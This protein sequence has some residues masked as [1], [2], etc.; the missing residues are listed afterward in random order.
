MVALVFVDG[1]KVAPFMLTCCF[2]RP[3]MI[4][5]SCVWIK[6]GLPMGD[7]VD[8][9]IE[10]YN[11]YNEL[12][13]TYSTRLSEVTFGEKFVRSFEI[14]I[15]AFKAFCKY[16]VLLL[17]VILHII[18]NLSGIYLCILPYI[19]NLEQTPKNTPIYVTLAICVWTYA[20]YAICSFIM[21]ELIQQI[22][23]RK[24]VNIMEALYETFC[25]S[26]IKSAPLI[27]LWAG[28]SFVITAIRKFIVGK[29]ESGGFGKRLVGTFI[30]I[31]IEMLFGVLMD[32]IRMTFYC[33]F[34]AIAWEDRSSTEAIKRGLK[35]LKKTGAEIF[36][37]TV[38]TGFISFLLIVPAAFILIFAA[39][40]HTF[41]IHNKQEL[42]RAIM[43]YIGYVVTVVAIC[44]FIGQ[45]FAASVYIW[46]KKWECECRKAR[47][48][49]IPEPNLYDIPT[50]S[51]LNDVLA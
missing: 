11:N 5:F 42:F 6:K 38:Q 41:D 46:H 50:P 47:L 8:K 44:E 30:S 34:P 7:F 21:L 27:I 32:F 4:E 10:N 12:Y 36:S 48:Q 35:V 9:V 37:A 20:T 22:S 1:A 43:L 24:K 17:P 45:M 2:A 14:L 25:K 28:I 39:L 40:T 3:N 49:N 18:I 26:L 31:L 33:I 51:L 15:D 13:N 16:P 23:T 29:L 19:N